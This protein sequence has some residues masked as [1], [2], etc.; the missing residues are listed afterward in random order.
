LLARPS[1]KG[2]TAPTLIFFLSS[3]GLISI[4][5]PPGF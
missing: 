4:F 1:R 3:S 2:K 5:I